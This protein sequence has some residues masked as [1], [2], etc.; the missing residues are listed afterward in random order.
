M[1]KEK[2]IKPLIK[3]LKEIS[4]ES[5]NTLFD[6]LSRDN[7]WIVL[8]IRD[9]LSYHEDLSKKVIFDYFDD[10]KLLIEQANHLGFV[11]LNLGVTAKECLTNKRYF[12]SIFVSIYEHNRTKFTYSDKI[13]KALKNDDNPGEALE[14]EKKLRKDEKYELDIINKNIKNAISKIDEDK[15]EEITNHLKSVK[16]DID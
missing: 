12:A 10:N 8:I 7:I 4:K 6:E 15:K 9:I 11:L 3:Y 1:E 2:S 14:K 5:I 16:I 13:M